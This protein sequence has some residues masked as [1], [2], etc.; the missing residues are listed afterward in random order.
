[1][2]NK[3]TAPDPTT[4]GLCRD[5]VRARRGRPRSPDR[6]DAIVNATLELL[7]TV[8][9]DQT[10]LQDIAQ[11]AGVGLGTIYRRWPTKQNLVIAAIRQPG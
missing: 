1:M 11:L 5:E 7:E 2:A 8:G 4:S 3:A 10:R 6:D 9:Y